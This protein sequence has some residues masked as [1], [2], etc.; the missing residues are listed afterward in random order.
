MIMKDKR[1]FFIG[2]RNAP[3]GIYP[4]IVSA[5]EKLTIENDVKEFIVGNYGM[6]D[7]M[8]IRA[9]QQTKIKYPEIV[10]LLLTPYHPAKKKI[11]KPAGFDDIYYPEGLEL[12]PY[13]AAIVKAN[14]M[15]IE[16]SE[17]L[18]A[19]FKYTASN[20]LHFVDFAINKGT[21]IFYI[22]Q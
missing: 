1:C 15:T 9:L 2:H 20:T 4:N 11:V 3:E 10:L 17:F 22:D 19:Y 8:V 18:I 12:V 16:T 7:S 5:I 6:F 14:K 13:R 21:K